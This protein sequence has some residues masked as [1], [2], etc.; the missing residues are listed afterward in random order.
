MLKMCPFI[1]TPG[2]WLGDGKITL[3][4]MEK[5]LSFYMRWVVSPID[6]KGH[7]K[8]LQ[9]I[10][11]SGF[12]DLMRNQ[13][14][15]Y[16]ITKD[17][18]SIDLESETLG[19]VVGVGLITTALIGWEFRMSHIGFE[20]FEFYEATEDQ[21]TYLLHA[22]YASNDDLRTIIHGKVWQQQ[23]IANK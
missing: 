3:S 2:N 23:E 14:D 20:G 19:K 6:E 16:N 13:F 5:D 4:M 22:E 18:F 15:F 9:E 1:L 11:I 10:Q 8:A 12:P 17:S 21:N 7:I